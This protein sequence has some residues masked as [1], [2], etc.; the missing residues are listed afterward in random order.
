MISSLMR[1][2]YFFD[3]NNRMKRKNNKSGPINLLTADRT[4][5]HWQPRPEGRDYI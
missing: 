2:P 1:N 5:G 4:E 3:N